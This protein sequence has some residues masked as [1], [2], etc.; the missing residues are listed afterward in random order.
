MDGERFD[1]FTRSLATTVSR[2]VGLRALGGVTLGLTATMTGKSLVSAQDSDPLISIGSCRN[3]C[4]DICRDPRAS[5]NCRS[6]C[7]RCCKRVISQGQNSCRFS[8]GKIG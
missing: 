3:Q 8:N 7:F 5:D 4:R 2:R 1:I 6:T